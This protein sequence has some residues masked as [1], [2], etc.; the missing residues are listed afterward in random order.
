MT[1]SLKIELDPRVELR[2]RRTLDGNILILDH[3]DIDII[4]MLEKSK[5]VTFPKKEMSDKVYNAQDR[6]FKRMFKDGIISPSSVRGGNVYGSMEAEIH[7][8]KVP[9]ID[10]NQAVL[11]CISEFIKDERPFFK[12]ASEY[13]TSRLDALLQPSPEE[14]TDLGDVEQKASKGSMDPTVRSYGFMYNYSLVREGQGE[15]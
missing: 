15:D 4:L 10:A 14:S 2:A 8:S 7:E 1:V 9:G 12:T 13:D 11:F 3:E 6:M 5:C